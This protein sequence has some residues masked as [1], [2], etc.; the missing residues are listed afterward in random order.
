MT[1]ASHDRMQGVDPSADKNAH[2]LF[3]FTQIV[4]WGLF[5]L[6]NL[7][8]RQYFV[9]YHFSE[10]VNSV[11]LGICLF[12]ITSIL[13]LYYRRQLE[14]KKL[15]S[16]FIHIVGGSIVGGALTMLLF[17]L[18][19]LPNQEAIWGMQ[20][21]DLWQQLLLGSPMVMFLILVWSTLYVIFKN[22]QQLKNA[23]IVQNSLEQ[24][25]KVAKLD[26]LLSQ[27]NP[28]F[29]FNAINNI[30]ALI[31][32]DADKAR[33][34]LADLSEVMR[35]TM[36]IDKERLIPFC[37]E[38]DVVKQYV[39]L[40]KLQFE[41]KL[42]VHFDLEPDTLNLSLPPMILQ[43]LIENAIKHGI[44][45]LKQGGDVVITSKLHDCQW[46]ITVENSGTFPTASNT[47]TGV[48]INN[49]K[50]RLFLVYADKA[51][52]SLK[53]SSKGVIAVITL[54]LSLSLN[55][56]VGGSNV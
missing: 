17:A 37:D 49:I 39:A 42:Q 32:E 50:Q 12:I 36:Q 11:V 35:Y 10:L 33:D 13:R 53:P 20:S 55:S 52:F 7:A 26:V 34:M 2:I 25:L 15:S 48:G 47:S 1:V 45:K 8:G 38:I 5:T 9:H 56:T 28:H 3:W 16:S 27:I 44:G 51:S 41:D 23:Q 18:I 29:I 24:S 46:I 19:I 43:L 14:G 54:P 21:K 4:G 30:R 22:Q 6:I 31:L 40:N